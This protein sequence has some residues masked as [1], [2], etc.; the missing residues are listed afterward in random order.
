MFIESNI[1]KMM[2]ALLKHIHNL[3]EKQKILF[4]EY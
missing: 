3:L 2:T 1:K 4:R